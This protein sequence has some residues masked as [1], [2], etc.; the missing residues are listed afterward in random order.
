MSF[1]SVV[2]GVAAVV[3]V[4]GASLASVQPA[5]SFN[6]EAVTPT[7]SE[8]VANFRLRARVPRACRAQFF[9]ERLP[10]RTDGAI[11]LGRL[12]EYCNAPE[13]Y[14]IVVD[15]TPGTLKGV[16]LT[17]GAETVILDGTGRALLSKV[18]G[19]LIRERELQ[20]VSRNG[21]FDANSFSLHMI[22][23]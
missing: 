5:V 20:V 11:P 3:T 19:P 7:S 8:A 4:S 14:A 22:T 10:A 16:I 13:G 12:Q 18:N 21:A 23:R 6:A 17:A 2:F 1:F 15:Y 9:P